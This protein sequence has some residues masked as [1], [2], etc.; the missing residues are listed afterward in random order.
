MEQLVGDNKNLGQGELPMSFSEVSSLDQIESRVSF[1]E[2]ATEYSTSNHT[3][4]KHRVFFP[5]LYG[6]H[7]EVTIAHKTT[8]HKCPYVVPN[9]DLVLVSYQNHKDL[10]TWKF[11]SM[12][13]GP[14]MVC[15]MMLK[16]A[17]DFINDDRN[18]FLNP[19]NGI[20]ST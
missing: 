6:N 2:L 11:G 8:H 9:N 17:H 14:G 7:Q 4:K 19:S 12:W 20:Y 10:G 18:H 13:H 5:W 16:M 15:R 1:S 3:E